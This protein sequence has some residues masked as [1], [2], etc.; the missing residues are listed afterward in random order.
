[1]NDLLDPS[2]KNLD[3][4]E[5]IERDVYIAN[6]TEERVND[7][8]DTMRYLQRGDESRIIAETKLNE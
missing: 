2:R 5:S 4:R 8:S 3:V 1:M 7:E 6:L